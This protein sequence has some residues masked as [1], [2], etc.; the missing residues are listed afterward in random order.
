MA[1][2][3][4]TSAISAATGNSLR[5]DAFAAFT[6]TSHM[7]DEDQPHHSSAPLLP[8]RAHDENEST[9]LTSPPA[10]MTNP[11]R[12]VLGADVVI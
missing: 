7:C 3:T 2:D 8:G 1:Q 5:G 12:N 4:L 10:E 9:G 6:E 11:M